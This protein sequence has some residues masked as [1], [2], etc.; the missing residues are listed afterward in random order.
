MKTQ[1]R[2]LAEREQITESALV[3]QLLE[4]VLRTAATQGFPSLETLDKPN[5]DARLYVRL[6][7]DDRMLLTSRAS[8]RGMRAATY[9][10]V[11]VRSHLRNVTPIPKDELAALKGSIAELRAIGTNLNQ[12][13]R[14]LNQGKEAVPGRQ[15]LQD[16]LRVAEGLRDHFKA[17]LIA[18]EKSWEQGHAE[19][20]H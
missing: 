1:V 18:N 2:A 8:A 4:V 5:R 11:L 9:V 13:A 3:K 15:D 20:S 7:P 16:M 6:D 17:L 19:E 10:S 14:A 12:M